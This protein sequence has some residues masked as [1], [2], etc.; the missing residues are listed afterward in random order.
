MCFSL[1]ISVR[2]C[3]QSGIG[4]VFWKNITVVIISVAWRCWHCPACVFCGTWRL[5]FYTL[6]LWTFSILFLITNSY[7]YITPLP[8]NV[9]WCSIFWKHVIFWR[10]IFSILVSTTA[11]KHMWSTQTQICNPMHP[12]PGYASSSCTLCD[13]KIEIYPHQPSTCQ[14]CMLNITSTW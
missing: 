4:S 13:R 2:P 3:A 12:F 5:G 10:P 8:A 11:P 9:T 6:P 1:F 14:S 7:F